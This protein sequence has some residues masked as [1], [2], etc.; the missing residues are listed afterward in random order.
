[1][2]NLER[3]CMTYVFALF[4]KT[5]YTYFNKY[6][7]VAFKFKRIRYLHIKCWSF[8]IFVLHTTGLPDSIFAY[9]QS[10]VGYTLE[11]LRMKNF[12]IFI[13]IWYMLR[14]FGK[15]EDHF[16]GRLVFSSSF[17][18]LNQERSGIPASQ[19]CQL[20]RKLFATTKL[21]LTFF[22]L[23]AHMSETLMQNVYIHKTKLTIFLSI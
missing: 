23:W 22:S 1:M 10:L 19:S 13:I 4:F 9:Q 14:S 18:M 6:I 11:G 15:F 7:L 21:N 8:F 12:G 17:G 16:C 2:T 3:K 20:W 5:V